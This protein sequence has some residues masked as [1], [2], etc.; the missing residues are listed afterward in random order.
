MGSFTQKKLCGIEEFL[1][2][3][4]KNKKTQLPSM[5]F[6][7]IMKTVNKLVEEHLTGL[8]GGT[9]NPSTASTGNL[10]PAICISPWG[11]LGSDK[12]FDKTNHMTIKGAIK[13]KTKNNATINL[14]TRIDGLLQTYWNY[15]INNL[16]LT[17]NSNKILVF[18]KI[19]FSNLKIPKGKY[20]LKAE[21]RDANKRLLLHRRVAIFYFECDPPSLPPTSRGWLKKLLFSELG[22]P[23]AFLRNLPIND[24]GEL[25]INTA[26]S[27]VNNVW[28]SVKLSNNQKAKKLEPIIV[29]ISLHEAIRETS[30]KWWIDENIEYDI[31]EIKR[32]KDIF[33]E[34]W[35]AY[36]LERVI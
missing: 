31:G 4:L 36:C 14:K 28:K 35:G 20:F 9:R 12:R 2:K 6:E 29:N 7:E 19:E 16:Q 10:S 27:E 1:S 33:D 23:K 30:L 18:P 3:Y 5:N 15:D 21:I 25:L 13:N 32:A 8:G 11:Y 24:K 34:M 26:H 17:P 22:G